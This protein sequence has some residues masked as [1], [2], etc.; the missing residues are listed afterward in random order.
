MPGP[1]INPK[2]RNLQCEIVGRENPSPAAANRNSEAL[3]QRTEIR[4]QDPDACR[5]HEEGQ[6]RGVTQWPGLY[7]M[8]LQWMY[9]ANSAQFYGVHEDAAYVAGHIAQ[10][11]G[12]EISDG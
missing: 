10:R 9:G 7:F 11:Y 5:H 8:G 6:Q 4:Y 2:N 3:S 12:D 1:G